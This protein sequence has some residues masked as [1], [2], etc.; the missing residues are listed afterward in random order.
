MARG[1][2]LSIWSAVVTTA[3]LW[4]GLVLHVPAVWLIALG[5]VQ[6]GLMW[7]QEPW[8]VG[9]MLGSIIFGAINHWSGLQIG[10]LGA[11]LL[12]QGW[13]P[14]VV[15]RGRKLAYD[16]CRDTALSAFLALGVLL[17]SGLSALCG[18]LVWW[19]QNQR[20]EL[21]VTIAM[22][23]LAHSMIA[24]VVVMPTLRFGTHKLPNRGR[25]SSLAARQRS[26]QAPS[27]TWSDIGLLLLMLVMIATLTVAINSVTSI[28]PQLTNVLFLIPIVVLMIQRGFDG[29]LLS[30]ALSLI[31][32]TTVANYILPARNP[33]ATIER[34]QI[35]TIVFEMG[36]YYLIS[37]VVGL[38]LDAQRLE[39]K[40]L[41]TLLNLDRSIV[42][43]SS[44]QELS[45]RLAQAV[46]QA[47]DQA[48]CVI[49]R[50]DASSR[51]LL[52]LS[53]VPRY[54]G[55]DLLSQPL[56]LEQFPILQQP[57]STNTARILHSS[58]LD[59]PPS[60]SALW[61]ETGYIAAMLI[62]LPGTEAP[63]GMVGVFDLRPER[64]FTAQ[65]MRLIE[66]M[67]SQ[68][69]AALEQHRLIT[70][71]RSQT[72]QLNAVTQITATLNTTLDLDL[73]CSKIITTIGQVQPY[74]W[75]LVALMRQDAQ[76][77][78]VQTITPWQSS[79]LEVGSEISFEERLVTIFQHQT[80]PITLN[81]S[82]NTAAWCQQLHQHHLQSAL[83]LPLRREGKCLAVVLLCSTTPHDFI[84]INQQV[85]VVLARHM[86]LAIS[87]AQFYAELARAYRAQ[88]DAQDALLQTERFRALGELASGIAHDFN[89]LL[90]GI[91]G[92]TQLLLLDAPPSSSETLSVIEQAARDGTHMIQRIQQF[93]G[94]RGGHINEEIDIHRLI[95]DVIEFTRPRWKQTQA[96]IQPVLDLQP[97]PNFWG[98]PHELRQVLVNLVINAI[99]AMAAGGTLTIHTTRSA[100]DL[101]IQVCDTG[102]GMSEATV[103]AMWTPFFTTK[104]ERGTGLGMTMV[105]SIVVQQHGG[106]IDVN[107]H[108][109][110]GT[111]I[112]LY[113]PY[114]HED[115]EPRS[116]PAS[117]DAAQVTSGLIL[118]VEH[119]VRVQSALKQLLTSWGHAV[120]CVTMGS[121]ALAELAASSFDLIIIDGS[122]IDM[123]AWALAAQAKQQHSRL[124][125]V[126]LTFWLGFND[127]EQRHNVFDA[128]LPKPFES[129]QLYS[130][131]SELMYQKRTVEHL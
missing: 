9:S 3:L 131:I 52:P 17:N 46:H 128:V 100:S 32:A 45:D 79:P 16:L 37:I 22:L 126:L 83:L 50:Y 98:S 56:Q 130:T 87:N 96:P 12:L 91:L 7:W 123:S 93:A 20:D 120:V 118:V 121:A 97:V 42:T 71:L 104:G 62:P 39:R 54:L 72:H 115:Q 84:T 69:A 43:A 99:D 122:L 23:W 53:R 76:A 101:I 67:S 40:R 15:F 58:N 25:F 26:I 111:C 119:D 18:T 116:A 60:T 48:T 35:V 51:Q 92:H 78:R 81:L 61:L 90:A 88:E 70:A 30:A 103:A 68:A 31:V 57:L 14:M 74:D 8:A 59:L 82:T 44:D 34:L 110:Q 5:V 77:A 105:H 73:V 55:R 125:V 13:L 95:H 127:N 6:V 24:L 129:Q 41:A 114:S 102:I 1:I 89:N 124:A 108:E 85:L 65:E 10:L 63:I 66:V 21:P 19:L 29:A 113:L 64:H 49:W 112:S 80:E 117:S 2:F 27:L 11:L 75:A 94:S 36:I 4:A 33:G 109:G 28:P 106:R 107:S 47:T 86:A 38:L